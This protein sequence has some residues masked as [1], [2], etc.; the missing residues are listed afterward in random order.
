MQDV[1]EILQKRQKNFR[2]LIIMYQRKNPM[3]QSQASIP[4]IP[5]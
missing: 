1:K 4:I 3:N 5:I 2:D